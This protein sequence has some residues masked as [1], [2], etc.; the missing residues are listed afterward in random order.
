MVHR[1]L[2]GEMPQFN[3]SVPYLI[4]FQRVRPVN[5]QDDKTKSW[6]NA[7]DFAVNFA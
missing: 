4:K 2:A 3:I 1:E 5:I 6:K 7:G